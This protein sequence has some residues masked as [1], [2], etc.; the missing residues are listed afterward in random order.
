[1]RVTSVWQ[2]GRSFLSTGPSGYAVRTDASVEHGGQG[3]GA[4][5]MELLLAGLAGCMGVSLTMI[6]E[7]SRL[8]VERI[9]IEVA[10]RRKTEA[11]QGFTYIEMVFQ[12]DASGD[13]PARRVWR[14]I[15]LSL[16]KYC[17]VSGSLKADIGLCLILNGRDT[18]RETKV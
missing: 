2:G 6:L 13:P 4:A 17:S 9:E 5:P 18:T 15:E 8:A 11:P 12:V 10:G 16:E 1:M 7:R 14:A 3:K